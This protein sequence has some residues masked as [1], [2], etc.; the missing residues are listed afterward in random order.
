MSDEECRELYN[1]L[2]EIL[3]NLGLRWV[4]ELTEQEISSGKLIKQQEEYR[5]PRSLSTIDSQLEPYLS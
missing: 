2:A 3:N 5:L 1:Q 4:V